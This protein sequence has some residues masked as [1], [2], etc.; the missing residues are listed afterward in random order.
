MSEI[1]LKPKK[2]TIRPWNLKNDKNTLK[3]KKKH[4]WILTFYEQ[5]WKVAIKLYFK[6]Q[7]M[8]SNVVS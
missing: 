4:L 2:M 8:K 6:S 5:R 1:P 7:L 3:P